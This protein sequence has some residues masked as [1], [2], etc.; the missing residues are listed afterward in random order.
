MRWWKKGI[1]I[2]NSNWAIKFSSWMS[3]ATPSTV[4]K[5]FF[6]TRHWKHDIPLMSTQFPCLTTTTFLR[7][8]A[9]GSKMPSFPVCS[10]KSSIYSILRGFKNP[11]LWREKTQWIICFFWAVKHLFMLLFYCRLK[12]WTMTNWQISWIF[13]SGT[14]KGCGKLYPAP[15]FIKMSFR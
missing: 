9:W 2:L 12:S 3:Y 4:Y 8:W 13:A 10:F 1:S 6:L 7:W 14:E 15:L 5:E 11:A